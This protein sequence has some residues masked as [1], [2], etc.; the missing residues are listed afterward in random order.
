[1]GYGLLILLSTFFC[2]RCGGG[3]LPMIDVLR[4][5]GKAG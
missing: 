3:S 1:M 5:D 2:L 4:A